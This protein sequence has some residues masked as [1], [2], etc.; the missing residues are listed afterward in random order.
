MATKIT[1]EEHEEY[2]YECWIMSGGREKQEKE[3]KELA[4]V[5]MIIDLESKGYEILSKKMVRQCMAE[6]KTMEV[7]VRRGDNVKLLQWST[8]N[9][10]WMQVLPNNLGSSIFR[11]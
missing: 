5:S 9:K 10:G 4:E 3:H 8:F 7:V 11:A 6:Y 1:A 2:K